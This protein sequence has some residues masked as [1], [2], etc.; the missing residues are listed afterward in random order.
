M[1][2]RLLASCRLLQTASWA[3]QQGSAGLV[4]LGKQTNGTVVDW[5][6]WLWNGSERMQQMAEPARGG[7]ERLSEQ[8]RAKSCLPQRDVAFFGSW[9]VFVS[10][11][12]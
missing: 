12:R 4:V 10:I 6:C 9:P 3:E 8:Q 11:C 7:R 1:I 5:N 2:G